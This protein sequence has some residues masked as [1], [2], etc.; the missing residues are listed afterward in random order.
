MSALSDPITTP[1]QAGGRFKPSGLAPLVCQ[2][3]P[4]NRFPVVSDERRFSMPEYA[5]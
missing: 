4:P 5:G 1:A 2:F 3:I